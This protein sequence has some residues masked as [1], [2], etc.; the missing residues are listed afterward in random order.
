ML[1]LI[2]CRKLI[3]STA[4]DLTDVEVLAIRDAVY[5]LA[6]ITLESLAAQKRRQVNHTQLSSPKNL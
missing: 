1:T 4:D 5:E 3:G 2:E 6:N